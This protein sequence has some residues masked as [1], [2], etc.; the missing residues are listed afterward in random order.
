MNRANEILAQKTD[1]LNNY[2]NF[3]LDLFCI[4]DTD[5]IF[6]HLNKAWEN[7]LGFTLEELEGT[8]FLDLVH[9]DDLN[10]TLEALSKLHSQKEI[11]FFENRYRCKDNSYK[12][13]EWQSYPAGEIIYAAARDTTAKKLAEAELIATNLKI[14]KSERHYRKAQEV[15]HVGSWEFDLT[16]NH[17]WGSDEGKRIYGFD[18]ASEHFP[19]EEVMSCVI[20]RERV[21]Q[22]MVDLVASNKPYDIIFEILPKNSA[23]RKTIHSLAEL[24]FDQAGNP[25]LVSGVL[26]DIT[27]QK[28]TEQELI[29][30]KEKA[31]ESDRLKSAFLANMSHEIRTPLNG[32]LGFSDLLKDPHLSGEEQNEYIGIIQKGGMRLLNTI[33]EIIDISRI[34]AG[35][36]EVNLTTANIFDQTSYIF[37]FFEKEIQ[38]KGL[39][40]S[41]KNGIPSGEFILKSDHFKIGSILTNLLK[42][43]IKYTDSGSIEFG[44]EMKENYLE[45]FVRDTG[46]G[47]PAE[48][49][50]AIFERFIQA[51][52][53][54]IKAL[55]GSGLGLSIAK[56]YVHMLGG[57]IWLESIPQKGST[58]YFTIPTKV[59]SIRQNFEPLHP[60]S[61]RP[62]GKVLK[63]LIVDD[64][65]ISRIL[66]SKLTESYG[67][68]IIHI[69][70]GEE[71][72]KIC[73]SIP[74]ID[75]ILMD[76]KMPVMDGF[77]TTRQ[78]RQFNKEVVIIAQ[79]AMEANAGY[80]KAMDAGC[81]SY[82]SKPIDRNELFALLHLYFN[83]K[84]FE[85]VADVV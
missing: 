39:T 23:T 16:N 19:A 47:I 29:K 76:I 52:I 67:K 31:E 77:E 62:I 59:Q 1:E 28:R 14:E 51:D 55:Q 3:S 48:R 69:H 20:E 45:Y 37:T 7:T 75:L 32:I 35:L 71:A 85:T 54:D 25:I 33:N 53:R 42:N 78:I 15:G 26:H 68:E 64:D 8:R 17:F 79:T 27:K 72:V 60:I 80:E 6:R 66:I 81:N 49:Q 18:P 24:V 65:L 41:F 43:A 58:F 57:R 22:A 82:L 73:H 21:E 2:F 61:I 40:F 9:P 83:M 56:A 84:D 4:A 5:A 63:I 36:M 12:W 46:C 38:K 11:L 13:L 34:E 50:E 10:P 74:D 70:T 44:L 30:A